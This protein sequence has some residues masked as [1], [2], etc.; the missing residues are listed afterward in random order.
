MYQRQIPL[1]LNERII[2]V[3]LSCI[4]YVDESG[5]HII[6]LM[7]ICLRPPPKMMTKDAERRLDAL[8]N[9]DNLGA[10]FILATHDLEIRGAGEF[11]ETNKVDKLKASVF[12]FIWNYWMQRLKR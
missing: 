9:L 6:R 7:L 1:L 4:N 2:L 5:V 3:W 12:R 11:L 10:G 8:E